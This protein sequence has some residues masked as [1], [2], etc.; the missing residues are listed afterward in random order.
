MT[1]NTM[2][3]KHHTA[4]QA[5]RGWRCQVDTVHKFADD[6]GSHLVGPDYLDTV[7]YF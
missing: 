1:S 5:A 2:V 3:P 7:A 4:I 6:A